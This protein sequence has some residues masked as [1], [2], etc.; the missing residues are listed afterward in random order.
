MTVLYLKVPDQDGNHEY[1]KLRHKTAPQPRIPHLQHGVK[2]VGSEYLVHH[3]SMWR[4]V[5][6]REDGSNYII[7]AYRNLPIVIHAN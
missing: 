4:R 6:I 3:N 7:S 1:R 5:Y 2:Q